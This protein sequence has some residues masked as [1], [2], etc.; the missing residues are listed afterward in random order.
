MGGK[1]KLNKNIFS[2]GALLQCLSA[3]KKKGKNQIPTCKSPQR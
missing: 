3:S 1:K 2:N